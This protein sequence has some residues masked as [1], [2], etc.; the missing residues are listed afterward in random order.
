MADWKNRIV[1]HGFEQPDQL[2]ANPAN[3][4]IHPRAQQDALAG[5]LGDVGWVQSVIVNQRTGHLVDGHLRVTLAMREHAT[6]IPVVYVDLDESEE[7]LVL[8]TIDPLSAM[9]AADKDKLDE[10]LREIETDSPAVRE[11]LAEVAEK[12]GIVDP[13]GVDFKEYDE[14][15][16]NEVEYITCPNCGHKWPK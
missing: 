9:A 8:A 16:A 11:M 15:V 1:G 4:R 7:A 6:E 5:V 13:N 14:S 3:W 12:N 10:L 2:L